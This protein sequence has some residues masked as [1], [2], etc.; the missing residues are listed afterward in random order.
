MIIWLYFDL[1]FRWGNL[2]M[3]QEQYQSQEAGEGGIAQ[4]IEK[5]TQEEDRDWIIKLPKVRSCIN[6]MQHVKFAE[7]DL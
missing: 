7:Y 1:F 6:Q 3:F 2:P 4:E 5:Y